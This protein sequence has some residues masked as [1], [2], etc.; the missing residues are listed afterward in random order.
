MD[1]VVSIGCFSASLL[2]D[3]SVRR[4]KGCLGKRRFEGPTRCRTVRAGRPQGHARRRRTQPAA[5][6]PHRGNEESGPLGGA[7]GA[8][9]SSIAVDVYFARPKVAACLQ[10]LRRSHPAMTLDLRMTSGE[11]GLLEDAVLLAST[12]AAFGSSI[13]RPSHGTIFPRPRRLRSG[14]D[15]RPLE[16][17][18]GSRAPD[19]PTSFERSGVRPDAK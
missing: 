8:P 5:R 14:F 6:C 18:A 13:L 12:S 10:A 19:R 16:V 7:V 4:G 15:R 1:T 17:R 2:D 11:A 9:P 3:A